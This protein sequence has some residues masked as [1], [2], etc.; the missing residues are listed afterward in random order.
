[1]NIIQALIDA[2]QHAQQM[3]ADS[4]ILRDIVRDNAKEMHPM[5]RVEDTKVTVANAPQ[6]DTWRP[7]GDRIFNQLMDAEDKRWRAERARE[8]GKHEGPAE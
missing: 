4:A 1:M 7:P 5:A 3:S 2:L 8:L 6:V